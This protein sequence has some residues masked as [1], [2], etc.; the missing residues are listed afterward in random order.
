MSP[1]TKRFN[2]DAIDTI[3]FSLKGIWL[4][5]LPYTSH[6]MHSTTAARLFCNLL[7][8]KKENITPHSRS[9][10]GR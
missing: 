10:E 8:K 7:G 2:Y 5:L 6:G 9:F 1:V 3:N 4:I